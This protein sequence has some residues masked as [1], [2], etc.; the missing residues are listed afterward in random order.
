MG[1]ARRGGGARVQ[2]QLMRV[3]GGRLAGRKLAEIAPDAAPDDIRLRPTADR[4]REAVFNILAHGDHPS[5]DGARA[6]DLFAGSG[7]LGIEALSRG[8]A[9]AVFVDDH[10]AARGLLRANVEALGLEGATKIYRRDATRLGPNRGAPFD[11]AFLDPP[12]GRG[13]GER[14]LASARDGGWLAP[15]AA[16][17][18]EDE[19]DADRP[20]LDGFEEIDRRRYG[21]A[22]IVFLH[23]SA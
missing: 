18:W 22:M 3:V 6:L 5:L 7:A 4:V 20:A 10:P 11:V 14:A 2:E 1:E 17:V 9:R 8:A 15:G 16:V 12:Y 13:L 23:R 21:A 19:V